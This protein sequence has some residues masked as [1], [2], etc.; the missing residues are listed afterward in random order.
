[1]LLS[2]KY[3]FNYNLLYIEKKSS[4]SDV[5]IVNYLNN[6]FLVASGHIHK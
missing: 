1:M 2:N 4:S 6:N 3:F 5:K